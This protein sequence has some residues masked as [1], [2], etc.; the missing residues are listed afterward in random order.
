M[1]RDRVIAVNIFPLKGGHAATVDGQKPTALPVGRTGFEVHGVRDHD[2][3]LYDPQER[4]FVSQRGYGADRKKVRYPQDGRLA[5]VRLDIRPDHVAISSLLLKESVQIPTE[6]ADGPTVKVDIWGKET[7]AV[8]QHGDANRF[9]SRLLERE[10]VLMRT[11][12]THD[13]VVPQK[14]QRDG[15]FNVAAAVDGLPFSLYSQ[16]TLDYQHRANNMPTGTVPMARYRGNIVMAGTVLGPGREDYIDPRTPFLVGEGERAVKMWVSKALSRCIVVAHDQET[17]D[18]VGQGLQVL[19]GRE[20]RIFT[21]EQGKF[22]GQGLVHA[23]EGVVAVDDP[24]VIQA[25]ADTPN[26][27]FRHAA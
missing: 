11:D 22:F 20:G 27:A 4:D 12:R 24:V 9:F 17:G 15:A 8:A 5:T 21:G 6:S 23:N 18:V 25:I 16:A 13:R 7:P 3:F 1:V 10:V 26:V 14:Y 2:F 19:H